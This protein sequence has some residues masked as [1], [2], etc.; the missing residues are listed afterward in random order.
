MDD[1]QLRALLSDAGRS[2]LTLACTGLADD[3]ADA[4]S[5]S[6]SLRAQGFTP[7][8][9]GVAVSQALLR[10]RARAK[11]GEFADSMLFTEDGL[12]QASRLGIAALHAGRF[13][14][15]GLS[16]VADLGCGIGADSL[17]LASVGCA[18]SA[19]EVDPVTAVVASYNLASFPEAVVQEKRAEDLNLDNVD[20]VFCDPARRAGVPGSMR[21][22]F[23]PNAFTPALDW[24]FGLASS[25]PVGIKLGPGLPHEAIP[26]D[27]E[28]LWVSDGG[29]AVEVGLWFGALARPGRRF[30]AL[31]L[32]GGAP[33]EILGDEFSVPVQVDSVGR[34]LYDPDPAVIRARA[35]GTL[36]EQLSAHTI[37]EGIAYLS[38]DSGADSPFAQ[39]FEVSDVLAFD[40]KK[41]KALVRQ[42]GIG[43]LEIKKRGADIDPAVLRRELAL[44]GSESATLFVTRV[45]GRHRAILATRR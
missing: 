39:R 17:A 1:F 23:S 11:F 35:L 8:V 21:R 32:G 34:F 19:V 16:R 9:T 36:A 4:A 22:V 25:L 12:Q 33:A 20:A 27:C 42:R 5:V 26:A 37:S 38:S 45:A 29:T 31:V 28:A 3:G 30:G 41:L 7:E 43:I 18:V 15:A 40:R 6:T 24:V 44:Q 10:R 14:A 2:A 13:R